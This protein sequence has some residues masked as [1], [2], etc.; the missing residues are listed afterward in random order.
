[1]NAACKQQLSTSDQSQARFGYYW[2]G[3]PQVWD[4]LDNAKNLGNL[5]KSD[6][7][8][9]CKNAGYQGSSAMEGKTAYDYFC[10]A[11]SSTNSTSNQNGNSVKFDT[12]LDVCEWKNKQDQY[13]IDVLG[14]YSDP[15]SWQCWGPAQ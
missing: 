10:A 15:A 7:D 4:C 13:V 9:Y 11:D 3:H 2:S 14:Q 8:Q 6:I 12:M 5:S 1:M